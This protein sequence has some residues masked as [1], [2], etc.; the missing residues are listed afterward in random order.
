MGMLTGNKF[1]KKRKKPVPAKYQR[2]NDY[3]KQ[4]LE[5]H[6]GIFGKYYICVYCGKIMKRENMQV[7]HIIPVDATQKYKFARLFL[8]DGVNSYKN[9]ASACRACN[10]SK[11]NKKGAW[12]W[13]G[14]IGKFLQP[15]IWVLLI[16][17][18]VGFF[19]NFF[20]NGVTQ[21]QAQEM[22]FNFFGVLG[23]TV[24]SIISN[25]FNAVLGLLNR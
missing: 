4:Y 10:A 8:P 16:S 19:A 18:L 5:W 3:R 13:R 15:V 22:F 9:L 14:I 24:A 25:G 20:I 11:S 17:F 7:D 2:S 1:R 6:P 21:A 23:D 12:V